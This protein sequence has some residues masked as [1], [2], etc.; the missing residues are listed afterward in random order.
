MLEVGTK[1][2][3]QVPGLTSPRR[4]TH[5]VVGHAADG[6][7]VICPVERVNELVPGQDWVPASRI[8]ESRVQVRP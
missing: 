7:L 5:E 1:V 2:T 3:I 8:D 4:A 6:K